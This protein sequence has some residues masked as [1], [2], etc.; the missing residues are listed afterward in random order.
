MN[1]GPTLLL[2]LC[3]RRQS[4]VFL[5]VRAVRKL[6][7]PNPKEPQKVG[8]TRLIPPCWHHSLVLCM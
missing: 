2:P 8:G 1:A 5:K 4:M 7:S 6:C 3:L